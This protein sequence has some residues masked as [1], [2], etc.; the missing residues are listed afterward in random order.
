MNSAI[1]KTAATLT[2]PPAA[3]SR[4]RAPR[5]RRAVALLA[6]TLA[7]LAVGPWLIVD[8]ADRGGA[9]AGSQTPSIPPLSQ[10]A[11]PWLAH[12]EVLGLKKKLARA[13]YSVKIDG[14]L[15]PIAKSA[16]A[17]YLRPEAAH[18]LSPFL[19]GA[20]EDTVITDFHNPAAWNNRFGLNRKTTFVE[21]PLTGPGGQLDANGNHGAPIGRSPQSASVFGSLDAENIPQV[22]N[23]INGSANRRNQIPAGTVLV[24]R[25]SRG[26]DGR[27]EIQ[28]Y[29][30]DLRIKWVTYGR[31]GSVLSSGS[32]FLI[33]GTYLYDLDGGVQTNSRGVGADFFWEQETPSLRYLTFE[34]GAS[35]SIASSYPC[36][37]KRPSILVDP[38]ECGHP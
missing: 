26:N 38:L 37:L 10:I 3:F 7:A 18:A 6:V 32:N 25:T 1:V 9:S 20:L 21:R 15:D 35:F 36:E 16:L 23:R 12:A 13:G 22:R 30:Y 5:R 4:R 14:N 8:G 33:K 17:D 2:P 19:A 27:M 31:D 29:G 24:Y 34:N 28:K 11:S